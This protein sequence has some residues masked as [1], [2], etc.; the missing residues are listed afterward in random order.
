MKGIALEYYGL[1]IHQNTLKKSN[2]TDREVDVTICTTKKDIIA[3][4]THSVKGE[5]PPIG[6]TSWCKW[7]QDL[8]CPVQLECVD[9]E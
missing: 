4:L 3:I 9:Q 6:E 2:P 7:Q 1:A 5:G 8:I